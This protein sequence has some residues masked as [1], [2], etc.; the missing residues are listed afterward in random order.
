MGASRQ[1]RQ[2]GVVYKFVAMPVAPASILQ[3]PLV[4]PEPLVVTD[5]S[6]LVDQ[7]LLLGG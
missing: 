7:Q 5:L 4:A 1:R 6:H 2:W 3:L